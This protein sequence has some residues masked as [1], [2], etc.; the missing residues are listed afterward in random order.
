[1]DY[2]TLLMVVFGRLKQVVTLFTKFSELSTG[3]FYQLDADDKVITT[4]G[5]DTYV[6]NKVDPVM[7]VNCEAGGIILDLVNGWVINNSGKT[8]R[9]QFDAVASISI[10]STNNTTIHFAIFKNGT[11]L[12][13]QTVSFAK[14]ES[15][16]GATVLN[17]ASSILLDDGDYVEVYCKTNKPNAS[18]TVSHIQLRFVE[19]ARLV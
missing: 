2:E 11:E 4:T 15:L 16:T 8:K 13:G 6:G 1:M 17:A 10:P 19:C 9:F 14:L 12:Q 18:F 3:S 5:T 7:V